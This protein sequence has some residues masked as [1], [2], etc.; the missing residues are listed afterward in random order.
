NF[1]HADAL[2][3][4]P[5]R[6]R[7][8][9]LGAGRLKEMDDAGISV[10]VLSHAGPAAQRIDA[11]AAVQLSRAANDRLPEI[12]PLPPTRLTALATTRCRLL[13]P[14]PTPDPKPPAKKSN[15]GLP[16]FGSV[17]GMI[18]AL[19]NGC[20][21]DEKQSCPIFDRA[22]ALHVPPYMHPAP[23]HPAVTDV[24]YKDYA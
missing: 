2:L 15:A 10:Q 13:P 3:P 14:L 6:R 1:A 11:E 7:L 9:D 4:L 20:F 21:T 16:S 17:G 22:H 24:Y 23:P 18:T 5:V 8:E 19:T 12:A